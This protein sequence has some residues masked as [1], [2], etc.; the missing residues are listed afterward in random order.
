MIHSHRAEGTTVHLFVRP[1][2]ED[3][4]VHLL[5]ELEFERWEGDKPITVWCRPTTPVATSLRS[6]LPIGR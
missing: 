3:A 1:T 6:H 5:R 2:G 4:G